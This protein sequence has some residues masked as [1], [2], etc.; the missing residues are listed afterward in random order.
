MHATHTLLI[1]APLEI[2]WRLTL[3]I[4]RWPSISPTMNAVERLDEG[5]LR[6][7]TRARVSQPMMRPAVWTVTDLVPGVRFVWETHTMGARLVGGHHVEAVGDRCRNT[8]T[9][10]VDGWSAPVLALV[11]GR[12]MRRALEAENA[13]FATAARAEVTSTRD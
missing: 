11:A 13:G 9:L 8:L 5:P 10:D 6:V 4:E 1:D 7:G 3:D 2:V 12:Q